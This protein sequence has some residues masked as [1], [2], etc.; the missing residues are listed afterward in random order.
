MKNEAKYLVPNDLMRLVA[1]CQIA[2]TVLNARL[3]T[4]FAT[5]SATALFAYALWQPDALRLAG[6]GAYALLVLWPLQRL[7]ATK[8]AAQLPQEESHD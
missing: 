2:L 3:L 6:A 7:D 4:L 5:L 1:F 8:I